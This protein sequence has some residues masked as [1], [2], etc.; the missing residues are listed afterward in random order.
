VRCSGTSMI[1]TRRRTMR[2]VPSGS[3]GKSSG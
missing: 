3:D 2:G 1:G